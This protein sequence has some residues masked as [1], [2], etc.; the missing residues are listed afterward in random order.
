MSVPFVAHTAE[1]FEC[2]K[3]PSVGHT[4]GT[5]TELSR[6]VP[7]SNARKQIRNRF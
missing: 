6:F 5:V 2:A 3:T 4:D 1:V 7:L